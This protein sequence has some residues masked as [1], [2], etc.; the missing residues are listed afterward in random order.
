[1]LALCACR[2]KEITKLERDEAANAA[3]EADFAVTVKEWSRAEGLF[4]RAAAL[5]PDTGDYWLNLGLVRMRLGNRDGARTAYKSALGAYKDA[6]DLDPA[7]SKAVIR[8]IYVL[9][10]LGRADEARSV[11]DKARAKTPADR[12]LRSFSENDGL[13]KMIADPGLKSV[14]P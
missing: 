14:S 10:V 12:L 2:H 6:A 3:S 11:L 9:V 13:S 5:C 7:N 4:A 8:R 1:V